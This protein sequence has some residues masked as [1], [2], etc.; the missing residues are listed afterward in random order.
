MLTLTDLSQKRKLNKKFRLITSA[1]EPMKQKQGG[2][3]KLAEE[4]DLRL[5]LISSWRRD[6]YK[7]M[8]DAPLH[9]G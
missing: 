2:L 8:V 6:F 4:L 1:V 3:K 7:R 5:E 9:L